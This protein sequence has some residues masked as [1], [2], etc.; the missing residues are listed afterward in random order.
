MII[1]ILRFIYFL[2]C[3]YTFMSYRLEFDIARDSVSD[4]AENQNLFDTLFEKHPELR[5]GLSKN[6]LKIYC[7]FL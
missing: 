2:R 6:F 7:S 4:L 1:H 3:I 5:N